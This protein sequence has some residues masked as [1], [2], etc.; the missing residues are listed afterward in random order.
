MDR[1]FD[2]T[3]E[4]LKPRDECEPEL[5][6]RGFDSTYEGLKHRPSPRSTGERDA[7]RQYL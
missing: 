2:S 7:F 3:Y 5:A 6:R 1:R 4:G